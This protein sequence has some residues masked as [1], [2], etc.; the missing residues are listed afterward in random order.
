MDGIGCEARGDRYAHT[1]LGL[2]S[3]PPSPTTSGDMRQGQEHGWN[4]GWAVGSLHYHK[5]TH[6]GTVKDFSLQSKKLNTW[7]KDSVLK[8][9]PSQ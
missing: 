9:I 8:M 5:A 3:W 6:S 2:G 1:A 4:G 7:V